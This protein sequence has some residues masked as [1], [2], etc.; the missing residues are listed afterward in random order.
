MYFEIIYET[1]IIEGKMQVLNENQNKK[2]H[3]E[4]ND[5]I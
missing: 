4:K 3:K 1:I 5:E 2:L